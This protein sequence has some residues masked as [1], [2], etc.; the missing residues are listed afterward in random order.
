MRIVTKIAPDGGSLI[1]STYIGGTNED[2]GDAVAIDPSGN[3][4]ITGR[5]WSND[6]PLKN[7][8]Q[9]TLAGIYDAF[10]TT[11]LLTARPSCILRILAGHRWTKGEGY[12]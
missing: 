9:P 4:Y 5:T 7:P 1:Y 3:A 2:M 10:V 6:F 8:V 12:R 11:S